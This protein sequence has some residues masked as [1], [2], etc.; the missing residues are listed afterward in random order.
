[1]RFTR[2][3]F[4]NCRTVV[5][6]GAG[7]TRGA[8]FV[9]GLEGKGPIP[10][11]DTDFFC[12]LEMLRHESEVEPLMRFCRKEFGPRE[13]VRMEAFFTQIEFA[14]LLLRGL[15]VGAGHPI[16]AYAK[17]QEQFTEAICT[18][19]NT[20]VQTPCQHHERLAEMLR[21]EDT[22]VSF[23]YDTVM[24][25]ALRDK[26]ANRWAAAQGYVV[27]VDSGAADWQ[28]P[29]TKG[30]PCREPIK[31]LKMHGSLNWCRDTPR[32][33][34]IALTRPPYQA[35][36]VTI[37][38]PMWNKPVTDDE[39][40]SAVWKQARI[41]LEAARVLV[42]VGYSMPPTD[43]YSQV[44]LRLGA[45]AKKAAALRAVVVADP[46]PAAARRVLSV[47]GGAVL[48]RTRVVRL[49]DIAEL[50]SFIGP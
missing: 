48:P 50:A 43:L 46:D 12:Q 49:K 45:N 42:V 5:V 20:F 32:S 3:G 21:S 28:A 40:F 33:K 47:L 18:L 35:K 23:N 36:Q 31:L 38:P 15:A 37:I 1:M 2:L 10:P 41:A 19:F 29:R 11:L 6:L 24:D 22:V 39:L 7:A 27:D 9:G 8:S 16:E 4:G 25:A 30:Q 17:A 26:A 34:H 13:V 44:W 14:N